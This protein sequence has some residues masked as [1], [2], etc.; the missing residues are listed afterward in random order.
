MLHPEQ[1]ESEIAK[2]SG[3]DYRKAGSIAEECGLSSIYLGQAKLEAVV[4]VAQL[5]DVIEAIAEVL[6]RNRRLS[7]AEANEIYEARLK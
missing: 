2:S 1:A 3:G 5:R 7:Y 6:C 4:L